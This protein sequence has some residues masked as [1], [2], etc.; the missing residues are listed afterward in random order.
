MIGRR[1]ACTKKGRSDDTICPR[2]R[3]NFVVIDETN[4]TRVC[5]ELQLGPKV[6]ERVHDV[7]RRIGGRIRLRLLHYP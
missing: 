2:T 7:C 5:H 1:F 4:N 3:I 6:Q